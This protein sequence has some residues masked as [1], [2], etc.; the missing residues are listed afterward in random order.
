MK[1]TYLWPDHLDSLE[2]KDFIYI[3]FKQKI[4]GIYVDV[5]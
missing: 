5:Q 4:A 2:N 1:K 3:S